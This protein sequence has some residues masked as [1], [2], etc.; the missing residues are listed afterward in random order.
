MYLFKLCFSLDICPRARLLYHMVNL[1]FSLLRT[2]ILSDTTKRLNWTDTVFH[3]GCNNLHSHQQCMR[4]PFSS[5]P[6]QHLLFVDFL[7]MDIL[8]VMSWNLIVVL[9]CISL[10]LSDVQCLFMFLLA[11]GVPS[12]EKCVFRSSTYF[13]I[14]HTNLFFFNVELHALLHILK[15]NPLFVFICRYFLPFCGLFSL[16]EN[17]VY[18]GSNLSLIRLHFFIFVFIF[19]TLGSGLEKIFL[20]FMSESLLP[21]TFL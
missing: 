7:M 6:L 9:I 12:L 1:I 17:T 8:T 10:I 18:Q 14:W 13:L 3:S 2:F 21:L 16:W 15:I 19:I 5:H 11:S 20:R 4:L